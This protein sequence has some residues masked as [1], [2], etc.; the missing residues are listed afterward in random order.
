M[1]TIPLDKNKSIIFMGSMN[2]LPMVYALE[3]KKYGYEVI[4]LVDAPQKDT[5]SRPENHYPSIHYPYPDWIVEWTLPLQIILLLNPKLFA[6]LLKKIIKKHT[7]K[8]VGCYVLNGFFISL[9]PYLPKATF[10]SLSHGSDLD[11]WA[12]LNNISELREGIFQS[13]L[14]KAIPKVAQTYLIKNFILKQKKGFQHSD[15]LLYLP[16]GF[17]ETGDKIIAEL[18]TQG[19]TYIQRFHTSFAPLRDQSREYK[20]NNSTLQIF[21]GVRFLYKSFPRGNRGYNKGNDIII[22]GLAKYYKVNPDIKIDFV[23]K[24][25]DLESAK[26]LCKKLGIES[27]ITWHKEMPF[28][29]LLTLY[30]QADIC[31]D[32]VGDHWMGAIG[33]YALWL[34]KPVITNEKRFIGSEFWPDESPVCSASNSDEVYQWLCKLSDSV[35]RKRVSIASRLFAD[36]Y[37][38]IENFPNAVFQLK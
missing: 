1:E 13:K 34:G 24:G 8:D 20:K 6:W 15:F 35:E 32:Q 37:L 14:M 16:P 31:F 18:Q 2:A 12:N 30:Q 21:S 3:M 25:T 29:D 22:E 7:K 33:V 28:Y 11:V 17:N 19:V 10:V 26:L 4:Y 5:L 9:S 38:D 23:E 36:Q 27:V